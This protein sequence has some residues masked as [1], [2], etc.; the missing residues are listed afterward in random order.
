MMLPPPLRRMQFPSSGASFACGH[1]HVDSDY[2]SSDSASGQNAPASVAIIDVD[3]GKPAALCL[4]IKK[5]KKKNCERCFPF[6][7]ILYLK[8]KKIKKYQ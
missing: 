4:K 1:G 3:L 8:N 6:M 7:T 5:T 2:R